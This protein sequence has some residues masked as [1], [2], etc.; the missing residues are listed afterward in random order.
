MVAYI[1]CSP[2]EYK[3]LHGNAKNCSECPDNSES[4]MAA[5]TCPCKEGYYRPLGASPHR[6]CTSECYVANNCTV[7]L[8]FV[9]TVTVRSMPAV[10]GW[11][12]GFSILSTPICLA[13]CAVY[14]LSGH[15]ALLYLCYAHPHAQICLGNPLY[16]QVINSSDL[17]ILQCVVMHTAVY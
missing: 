13:H 10:S 2:G 7:G 14:Y 1:A 5:T 16:M 3:L 4:T 15:L 6:K 11:P 17:H 8:F 12:A 9:S